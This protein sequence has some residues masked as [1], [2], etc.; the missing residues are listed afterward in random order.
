M[1]T[2]TQPSKP[3]RGGVLSVAQHSN[4]RERNLRERVEAV[5]RPNLFK[6]NFDLN[7]RNLGD[8]PPGA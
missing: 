2:K 6:P 5:V 1:L 7:R 8:L 3:L 4:L